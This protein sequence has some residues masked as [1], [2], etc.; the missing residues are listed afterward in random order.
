MNSHLPLKKKP[1]KTLRQIFLIPVALFAL[2]LFGLILA[3]VETGWVDG[4]STLAISTSLLAIIWAR[5][6]KKRPQ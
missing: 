5:L 3:L 4:I 6:F 2:G 1:R